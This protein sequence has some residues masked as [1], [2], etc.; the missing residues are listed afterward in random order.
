M[1]SDLADEMS[2]SWSVEPVPDEH[3]LLMRVHKNQIDSEGEPF[4]YAFKNQPTPADGMSTDWDKYASPRG[5]QRGGRNP[6]EDY[7]VIKFFAGDVR[8][9]PRQSVVHEPLPTNRAHTE[10][11]GEKKSTEVRE[12]FMQIYQMVVPVGTLA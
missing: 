9:I 5:S 3:Y 6:P 1:A 11:F 7:A 4:P 2:T 10:V 12:R 8:A